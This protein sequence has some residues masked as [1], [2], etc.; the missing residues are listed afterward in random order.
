MIYLMSGYSYFLKKEKKKKIR[1]KQKKLFTS[2][3]VI[4]NGTA[5][6]STDAHLTE[7]G[8]RNSQSYKK[9]ISEGGK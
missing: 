9:Q 3:S 2:F 7:T 8:I 1:N 5:N 6:L 4:L